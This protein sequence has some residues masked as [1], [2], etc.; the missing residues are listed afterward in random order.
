MDK[1]EKEQLDKD[2]KEFRYFLIDTIDKN[3]PNYDKIL[4]EFN[5]RFSGYNIW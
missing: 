2:L 3:D 4:S 1:L 5:H